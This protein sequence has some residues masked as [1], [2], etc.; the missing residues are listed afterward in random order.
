MAKSSVSMLAFNRGL[1][2]PLGLARSDIARTAL[3]AE[4][5][6]NWLPRT[7][8]SMTL[9]PG[10]EYLGEVVTTAPPVLVPFVFSSLDTA[11]LEMT[12]E[13]MRVWVNE[14]LLTRPSVTSAVTNGEFAADLSG[15]SDADEAGAT[16]SWSSGYMVLQ[17]N[18]V[19]RAIRIQQVTVTNVGVEHALRITV[20]RGPVVL[21][22][23]STSGGDN[24]ISQTTLEAG[25]HS[26]AFTPT[27]NF[28][29]WLGNEQKYPSFV[30]S[31]VIEGAGIVS[32]PTPWGAD[33]LRNIRTVQSADV[34][35]AACA[36]VPQMRI[37]RRAARSWSI[38]RYVVNDGPFR[39][40]NLTATTI[41]ASALTGQVTLTASTAIFKPG[42]VDSYW[43]L[44]SKGQNVSAAITGAPQWSNPIRVVGVG[45]RRAFSIAISGTWTANVKRQRSFVSETGPWEDVEAVYTTTNKTETYNDGLDNSIVWY[46]FGVDTGGYT[47]GTVNITLSYAAGSIDGIVRMIGFN[48]ETSMFAEV[49]SDLGAITATDDWQ[50][51]EWSN[52]RGWPSAVAFHD[53]RLWWAGKNRVWGSVS[54]A[55]NSF[56]EDTEG[57]SGPISRSIGTGAV[58][59][60]NWLA[61]TQRMFIGGDSAERTVQAS[62]FDEVL[63]PTNFGMRETSTIGSANVPAVRVDQTIF[64]VQRSGTRVYALSFD[65]NQSSGVT[66]NMMTT[67][68]EVGLPGIERVAVQRLPDTRVHFVRGDGT[69]ALFVYDQAEEVNC[70]ITFEVSGGH[71]EEVCTLPG[72]DE[73][74]VYY[75]VRRTINGVLRWYLE[76]FAKESEGVGDA[77]TKLSDSC[78]T[79]VGPQTTT[80]N[81]LAHL[82]GKS[83]V[84]WS[85]GGSLGTFTVAGGSITLPTPVTTAVIGLPYTASYKST[86]LSPIGDRERVTRIGLLLRH[87]H[88]NGL[89]YG[90]SAATLESLPRMEL[91][92]S[93]DPASTRVLYDYQ[94]VEFAGDWGTD[95][96]VCLVAASP[97]PCTVLGLVVTVDVNSRG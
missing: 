53:G 25:V 74:L 73:D 2:S 87:V 51:G 36:G 78:V 26:L 24:Y 94:K 17:G 75:V 13:N 52:V 66:K 70:W 11:L 35:F 12:P 90:K 58:D 95:S 33:D 4:E 34:V 91:E 46:R 48:S 84:V 68:P 14:S 38:A 16:S 57:D 86:K 79:Y 59:N 69:V 56:D 49:I 62:A 31:C 20:L 6:V 85:G 8:G 44:S 23:G 81:G 96:R 41:A 83:V 65:F 77:V 67:V 28:Y 55:F 32:I 15:W 45:A 97:N 30:N 27:G 71:V 39:V 82:D 72:D 37:E 80:I 76:R 3:S 22:V 50:E 18:G 63:T 92:K 89:R 29:I 43:K 1:I 60:I 54:D 21:R 47:S 10:L 61:S 64:F 88:A 42:H 7:L 19:S 9:R 5:C 40:Q 93:V